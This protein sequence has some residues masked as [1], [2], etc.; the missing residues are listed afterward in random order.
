MLSLKELCCRAVAEGTYPHSRSTLEKEL[1][2]QCIL[3][4]RERLDLYAGIVQDISSSGHVYGG[5]IRDI[6][7]QRVPQDIDCLFLSESQAREVLTD[8]HPDCQILP[9][10]SYNGAGFKVLMEFDAYHA[11]FISNT[12]AVHLDVHFG[13]SLEL[14][15]SPP[16]AD[17]NGLVLG[18]NGLSARTWDILGVLASLNR[19][20]FRASPACPPDRK[21]KL[22]ELGFSC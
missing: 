15:I 19:G 10:A 3:R 18:P 16:D 7:S 6:I 1:F 14:H 9:T 12:I 13:S 21:R 4:E 22:K 20:H 8:I 17:I 2:E 11:R 5:A